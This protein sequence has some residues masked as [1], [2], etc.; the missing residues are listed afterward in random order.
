MTEG[1]RWTGNGA[2]HFWQG[3]DAA[4]GQYAGNAPLAVFCRQWDWTFGSGQTINRTYGIFNDTH[5]DEPI[6]FA[7]TLDAGRQD[8]LPEDVPSTGWPPAAA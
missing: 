4:S 8:G 7:R 2:I 5:V 3:Q 6:T 1:A